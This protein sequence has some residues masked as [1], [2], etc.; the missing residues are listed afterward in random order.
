MKPNEPSWMSS[1]G[2]G[3]PGWHI[4]CSAMIHKIFGQNI[5][6]HGGGVDLKY[7]NFRL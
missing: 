2:E 1:F 3:R 4:E 7:L 6:V 5:D